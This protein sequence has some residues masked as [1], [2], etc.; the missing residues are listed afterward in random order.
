MWLENI[1]EAKNKLGITPKEMSRKSSIGLS[2][3]TIIR[4]LS[5]ET[6]P[7]LDTIIDMGATVGL[8][9]AE[10]F[11]DTTCIVADPNQVATLQAENDLLKLENES[12]KN[13]RDAL[14][15]ENAVL[16]SKVETLRDKVDTLKDEVI[17]THNYYIKKGQ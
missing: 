17:A 10:I 1:I 5:R 9:G 12:L 11:A 6:S 15:A 16:K 4:V 7:R 8:S 13:E 14:T 3:R 2:E